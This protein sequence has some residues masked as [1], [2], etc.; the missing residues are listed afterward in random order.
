MK[1][2]LY[3]NCSIGNHHSNKWRH[4]QRVIVPSSTAFK[5]ATTNQRRH[6]KLRSRMPS[7]F[8]VSDMKSSGAT[9]ASCQDT[10]KKQLDCTFERT[11]SRIGTHHQTCGRRSKLFHQNTSMTVA[12][13]TTFAST[14]L[15]YLPTTT[16]CSDSSATPRSRSWN[17]IQKLSSSRCQGCCHGPASRTRLLELNM[18]SGGS[19][20]RMHYSLSSGDFKSPIVLARPSL[21]LSSQGIKERV[22]QFS[23]RS[24]RSSSTN[25]LDGRST[26]TEMAIPTA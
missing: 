13:C 3:K 20:T 11:I 15:S 14:L 12:Q 6:D 26:T 25:A 23:V 4:R 21:P 5:R 19:A 22:N 18:C 7:D 10:P 17:S 16:R 2:S 8:I 9:K 1:V 24:L